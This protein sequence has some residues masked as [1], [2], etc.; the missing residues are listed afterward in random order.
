MILIAYDGSQHG[1]EAIRAAARLTR[2]PAI[3][4][5]VI[6]P[7]PR[8]PLATDAAMGAALDQE[9]W[10]ERDR[11]LREQAEATAQEGARLASE[12]GLQAEP[13]V[14]EELSHRIWRAIVD[15]ADGRAAE[16]VVVG[17]RGGHGL[18]TS[19]PGSVSRGVMAHCSRPVLVV[20]AEQLAHHYTS[21]AAL[22]A[23]AELAD[24]TCRDHHDEAQRL[25]H[26]EAARRASANPRRGVSVS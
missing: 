15:V 25:A 11:R 14:V 5:H 21:A 9:A 19:L 24:H 16:L 22:H 10:A 18:R 20:Q 7:A 4:L 1:R 6:C 12:A 3:V 23:F 26:Q 17:R 8:M 2:G 13:L